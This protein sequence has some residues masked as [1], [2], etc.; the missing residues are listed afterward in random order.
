MSET[1]HNHGHKNVPATCGLDIK[2]SAEDIKMSEPV[3][4]MSE[5]PSETRMD[6]GCVR[7]LFKI[8]I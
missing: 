7:S 3:M 8:H 4:E 2:M 5:P 1:S 6:K